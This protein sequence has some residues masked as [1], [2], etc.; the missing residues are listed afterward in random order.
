MSRRLPISLRQLCLGCGI[1]N[2]GDIPGCEADNL[3][4]MQGDIQ[5]N[6]RVP[7]VNITAAAVAEM[8]LDL[9][10]LCIWRQLYRNYRKHQVTA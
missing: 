9:T 7:D 5:K 8:D 1:R 4:Q 3:V 10:H 6:S 2:V